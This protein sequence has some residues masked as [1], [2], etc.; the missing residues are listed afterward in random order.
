MSFTKELRSDGCL[1]VERLES[2]RLKAS[3]TGGGELFSLMASVIAAKRA[4]APFEICSGICFPNKEKQ[5][6][7]SRGS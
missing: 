3:A 4:C 2:F 5:K 6:N 7:F 1:R